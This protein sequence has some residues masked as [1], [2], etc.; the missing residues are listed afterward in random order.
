MS[1]ALVWGFLLVLFSCLVVDTVELVW[2]AVCAFIRAFQCWRAL[3][4][5]R[6]GSPIRLAVIDGRLCLYALHQF[7]EFAAWLDCQ[8]VVNE[9]AVPAMKEA[10]LPPSMQDEVLE[11][12]PKTLT[13]SHKKLA[14]TYQRAFSEAFPPCVP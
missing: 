13:A 11:R 6:R 2:H 9:G 4:D 8:R 10:G 7:A 3:K 12:L 5:V 14:F 1:I